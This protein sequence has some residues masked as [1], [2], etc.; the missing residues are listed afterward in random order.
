MKWNE[1][2]L[3]QSVENNELLNVKKLILNK[4][5]NQRYVFRILENI[6]LIILM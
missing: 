1:I 5:Y 4:I 2:K 6:L 3:M